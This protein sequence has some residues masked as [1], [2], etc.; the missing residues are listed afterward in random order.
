MSKYW[1]PLRLTLCALLAACQAGRRGANNPIGKA[2]WPALDEAFLTSAAVTLNFRLGKP[3]PL[4]ILRDGSVL[5]RRTPPRQR[6]ADLYECAPSGEIKLLASVDELLAGSSE[7]LSAEESARRERTRTA[8]SGVVDI[9]VSDDGARVLLPLGE[10]VFVLERASGKSQELSLGAGY[11]LDPRISPDG[12]NVAFVRDGDVWVI[13]ID[14]GTPRKLT[15]QE[16]ELEYGAAEFVAQEELDRRRGY[17]WS[18]DSRMIAFQRTDNRPVDTIYVSDPRHPER[19]PTPFKYPRA[20]TNNARVD[21]GIVSIADGQLRWVRWDLER[22]PYLAKLDWPAHAPLSLVV[23]NRAQTELALLAVDPESG[24]T[25]ELLHDRDERWLNLP[26]GAPAWLEDGSGFLWLREES[27]GWVLELHE[28]SGKRS[29]VL[30]EPNFGLHGLAGVDPAAGA[31]IVLASADPRQQ[32][33]FSVPLG[34][35]AALPLTAAGGVHTATAAHGTVVISSALHEGGS[36][37]TV[38]NGARRH[39]LPVLAERPALVP[40]TA[41]EQ[42]ELPGRTLYTAITRPRDFDPQRRYPVLL[43]VYAGPH[44]QTVLDV[45]DGYLLDQW[46]ADAGFIV[47]RADGR[48]TPNRGHDFERAIWKDLISAPLA[49]QIAALQALTRAHPELDPDRVGV[50]GWS[51]GGYFSTLALLLRPD[52][53]KA[54]VAGAPVTDWSLYDTAYTERYMQT[55]AENPTGYAETSALTHASKLLRPL[56]LIHGVTDD[57]VHVAHSLALIEAL[58]AAS[59]RADVVLLSSTHMLVDP[60]QSFAREKLQVDFFREHLGG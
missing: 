13:A 19:A 4:A 58:F 22:F 48:G 51:F 33:V 47:V 11:P 46:Y 14:G 34:G 17:V 20:G 12:R 35:G 8:T 56:L 40:T 32:H 7:Q 45:R 24:E 50:F 44:V 23:L 3:E 49:D 1:R 2:D 37:V 60:K 5:F 36:A 27:A 54:A 42:V 53:F 9:D 31:A 28:P 16:G 59:K 39:Q 6:Q 30:T 38:V 18:P 52:V 55:P 10:R 15:T 43:K 29:R 25:R 21:L 41:F 57:N 26:L